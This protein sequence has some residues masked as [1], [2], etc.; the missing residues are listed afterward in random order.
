MLLVLFGRH[1]IKHATQKLCCQTRTRECDDVCVRILTVFVLSSPLILAFHE[2]EKYTFHKFERV[3]HT[4][5]SG[6][7]RKYSGAH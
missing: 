5:L 4:Y 7:Y 1:K 2:N 6:V 3:A